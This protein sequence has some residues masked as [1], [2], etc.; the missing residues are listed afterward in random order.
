MKSISLCPSLFSHIFSRRRGLLGRIWPGWGRAAS[1]VLISARCRAAA[2]AG[3]GPRQA[4]VPRSVCSGRPSSKP[5]RTLQKAFSPFLG[6]TAFRR[7]AAVSR[8][9]PGKGGRGALGAVPAAWPAL[10]EPLRT[11]PRSPCPS[12]RPSSRAEHGWPACQPS[13]PFE[14]TFASKKHHFNTQPLGAKTSLHVEDVSGVSD[15]VMPAYRTAKLV[16]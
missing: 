2:R 5:A 3:K 16:T 15:A 7:T 8:S 6:Q 12:V 10:Q 13:A 14:T 9:A 1:L 11:V 4:A